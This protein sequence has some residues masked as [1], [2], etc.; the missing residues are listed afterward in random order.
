MRRSLIG[1]QSFQGRGTLS[2]P[3]GRF[4]LQQLA[5]V[6]DGW[7]LEESPQ[8]IAT[9]LEPDRAREVITSNDSPDVGFEQSINPYRGCS[10]GCTYCSSPRTP[11]LMADGSTREIGRLQVGDLI[12]GTERRGR[13]R[14][15]VRTPVLARWAVIKPAYRVTLK[16][17]TQLTI[18]ADHR[19]LTDGGWKYVSGKAHGA[20]RRPPL[21][22]ASR[23][24]GT[25][26]FASPV[27]HDAEYRRGY[28]SGL[29]RS[30]PNIGPEPCSGTPGKIRWLH[31]LRL[32]LCDGEALQR[33]QTWLS[34]HD[35]ELG[36]QVFAMGA[37]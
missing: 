34:Y 17:D 37:S 31:G 2:N 18:G 32:A 15:Y 19:F 14:R 16:D 24:M 29:L 9:S 33:A 35:V 26:A 13:Y 3:P 23:L 8:S 12:Y 30:G 21:T 25:G 10:H 11:V 5:P 7:Y 1:K 36:Q 4:E 22:L 27:D 6:D 28:L 20:Q